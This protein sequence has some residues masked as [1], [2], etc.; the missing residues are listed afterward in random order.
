MSLE[1]L[2]QKLTQIFVLI[3]SGA[4]YLVNQVDGSIVSQAFDQLFSIGLLVVLVIM[5]YREWKN[6]REYNEERDERLET[7]IRNNTQALNSFGDEIK[8]IH[9]RIDRNQ[10]LIESR[11]E[12]SS[13]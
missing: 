1:M 10:N 2:M 13:N 9:Q 11:M 3:I 7:L 5:L 8:T 6:A 4:F 12:S